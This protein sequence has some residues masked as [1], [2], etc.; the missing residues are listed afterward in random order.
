MWPTSLTGPVRVR[1]G[2]PLYLLAAGGMMLVVVLASW[3]AIGSGGSAG[4]VYGGAPPAA[5]TWLWNGAGYTSV[6]IPP[7]GPRSNAVEMAYD[8]SR[9]LV[10]LWDHGCGKVVMGF[11]GG[12]HDLVNRTYAWDGRSWAPQATGTS[13]TAVGAGAMLY[14]AAL[15]RVIYVNGAGQVWEWDGG[16]WRSSIPAPPGSSG[17]S[18]VA[19]GYEP[20]R[21][22]LVMVTPARTLTWDGS[23]WTAVPGGIDPAAARPDRQ[24]VYDTALKQLVYVAKSST[25]TWDGARWTSHGQPDLG[26]GSAGYDPVR[27]VVM[28]VQLDD[29][30]CGKSACPVLTWTWDGASWTKVQVPH[31]PG[32]A[33]T[34]SATA[35]PPMAFD[36]ARG[37]MVLFAGAS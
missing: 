8:R 22:L 37:Q 32:L 5:A 21:N 19:A 7:S 16:G 17:D 36:E 15:Q 10:L 11:T 18:L 12:C 3:L 9:G 30:A 35:G 2:W 1:R 26:S 31:A 27:Q 33:L 24:L 14:D 20:G 23:R 6:E 4:P 29:S 34:R 13:P 28:A 25:W